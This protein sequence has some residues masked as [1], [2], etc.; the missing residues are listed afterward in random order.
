[1]TW[2]DGHFTEEEL[3]K[4]R[5][6]LLPDVNTGHSPPDPQTQ[7]GSEKP[8]MLTVDEIETMQRQAY[9]EAFQKGM[10]EGRAIGLE[11]GLEQGLKEGQ[12]Q[13]LA[14]GH[15]Q[16]RKHYEEKA[17]Q[18]QQLID[19]LAQPLQAVDHDVEQEL[20]ALAIALAKQILRR[21]L[22]QDAGQIVAV[23]R[24]AMTLL[25][26]NARNIQLILHPNDAHLVRDV[27]HVEQL[28]PPWSLIE[29]PLLTRG[30]CKIDTESSFI[31][32]TIEKRMAEVIAQML[33]DERDPHP[34]AAPQPTPEAASSEE[35]HD[36]PPTESAPT[37][38]AATST[39]T[40][41]PPASSDADRTG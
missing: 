32:A 26:V 1:M 6:W 3:A 20:V 10:E 14:E 35:A 31:D 4:L 19:A 16:S 40:S 41:E 36:S 38:L 28:T 12:A 7:Q 29:D 34:P 13:G 8:P 18:L 30:G 9:E 2:S 22:K 17:Y 33:G 24:E 23:V 27:L 5:P 11:Q 15:E 25:P 21:E 39:P 37:Q